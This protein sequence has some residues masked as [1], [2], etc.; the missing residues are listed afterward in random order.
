MSTNQM[1]EY[2]AHHIRGL[3]MQYIKKNWTIN[4]ALAQESETEGDMLMRLQKSLWVK[5]EKQKS[6]ST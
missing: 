1:R 3:K 5:R 6:T 4:D 2:N